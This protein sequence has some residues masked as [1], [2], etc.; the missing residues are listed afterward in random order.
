LK[1]DFM[2]EEGEDGVSDDERAC[3]NCKAA[4]RVYKGHSAAD[5]ACPLFLDKLQ[6]ALERDPEG[7][8][9]YFLVQ[10]NPTP[11]WEPRK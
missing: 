7:V 9:P 8:Y 3:A 6:R 1:E 2:E 10:D 5:R 11:S 4:Y